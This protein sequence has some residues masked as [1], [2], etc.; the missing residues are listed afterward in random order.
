[1]VVLVRLW[2]F[3]EREEEEREKACGCDGFLLR[4]EGERKRV[5]PTAVVM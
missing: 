3:G 4:F 2:D 5:G 1:M